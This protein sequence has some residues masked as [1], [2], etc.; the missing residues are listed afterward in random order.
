MHGVQAA[1]PI[2]LKPLSQAVHV[3][4]APMLNV[5]SEHSTWS[6]RSALGRCPAVATEQYTA[7]AADEYSPSPSQG[8]QV[9]PLGEKKPCSH[10]MQLKSTLLL[11]L[12]SICFLSI[13]PGSH[14][15]Q[16]VEPESFSEGPLMHTLH[17]LSPDSSV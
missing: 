12:P 9:A 3:S 5:F 10:S 16:Y 14:F 15:V 17:S 1:D 2:E 11:L 8:S 7:P 13:S 4:F 6:V